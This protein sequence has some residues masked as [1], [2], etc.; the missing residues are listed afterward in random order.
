VP[1][2]RV[3]SGF[4]SRPNGYMITPVIRVLSCICSHRAMFK[5]CVSSRGRGLEVLEEYHFATVICRS[6]RLCHTYFQ[7]QE[8]HRRGPPTARSTPLHPYPPSNPIGDGH[9]WALWAPSHFPA[10]MGLDGLLSSERAGDTRP[11]SPARP[12]LSCSLETAEVIQGVIGAAS[13][14]YIAQDLLTVAPFPIERGSPCAAGWHAMRGD[15]GGMTSDPGYPPTRLTVLVVFVQ[16]DC[17][18]LVVVAIGAATVFLA[19]I[20][21]GTI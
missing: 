4:R 10:A 19:L 1:S 8:Q 6:A 13:S 9:L 3:L 15:G 2:I 12:F 11:S 5:G 18:H 7:P 17:F 21:A 16:I 14:L 20:G